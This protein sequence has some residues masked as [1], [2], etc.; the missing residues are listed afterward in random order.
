[1]QYR[2]QSRIGQFDFDVQ[3]ARYNQFVRMLDKRGG[4][5]LREIEKNHFVT[6]SPWRWTQKALDNSYDYTEK[7]LDSAAAQLTGFDAGNLGTIGDVGGDQ[8]GAARAL[9]VELEQ[10]VAPYLDQVAQ[11][12]R[13]ASAVR[14]L[15]ELELQI[16]SYVT[17]VVDVQ[18][19]EH[20]RRQ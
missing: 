18:Q 9:Y 14:S 3:R 19:L 17:Q 10:L 8:K 2:S 13:V 7:I 16:E 15:R 11:D 4:W 6:S 12:P 20:Y 5:E 1:V